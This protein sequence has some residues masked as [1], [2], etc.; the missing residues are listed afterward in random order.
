MTVIQPVDKLLYCFGHP[1]DFVV[2]T[3]DWITVN[4]DP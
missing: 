4:M 2:I 3:E 1:Y